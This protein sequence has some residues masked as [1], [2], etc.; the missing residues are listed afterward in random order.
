MGHGRAPRRE[1]TRSDRPPREP[2]H[3]RR[4]FPVDAGPGSPAGIDVLRSAEAGRRVIRG[5][6]WR[7]AG[8]VAGILAGI[9]T[10]ALVL[11]H[12]GVA[13][14]GRYVTVMSLVAIASSVVDVGL[15][16]S[17]SRELAL[18]E[19]RARLPLLAN[20]I[21]QRLLV[22][23]LAALAILCFAL[24]AGYPPTMRVGT[25][26]AG[27]GMFV[28]ALAD[29]LLLPLSV[30]LR[31][32]GLAFVDFLKQLVSLGGVALLVALGAGLTPFF[33]VLILVGLAVLAAV[34]LL[35]GPGAFVRP[36]FDRLD[37]RALLGKALPLAAA[38]VLGQVYFRLVILLM[39]LVSSPRQTGYYGGSL[40]AIEALVGIP[41]LIAGV[42]LPLL[43]AAAR[44]D[45]D[46]LR[47]A[48][49]GLSEGAV[50]AGVLVALVA[51]RAAEPVMRV[52]GGPAF[53]PA[54]AVLRIQ[55]CALLFGALVQIWAVALVA[56]GRQRELILANALGLLGIGAFAAALVVPFGARGG[57]LASVLAD[58]SL[59]CV[60]HWRL[61]AGGVRVAIRAGFLG[62]VALAAA[63]AGAVLILPS[64]P[65]LLA[66][67]LA[68][69]LFLGVGQL[70]GMVP[71]AIHDAF[72]SRALFDRLVARPSGR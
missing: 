17:A 11:R 7:V 31:N 28:V 71:P 41:I 51:A 16:V 39:S 22:T 53:V 35:A 40:R 72:G 19:P 23:P 69:A 45:R 6:A 58:A 61:R 20:V 59:A 38:L 24:A 14:S 63:A 65:D 8:S 44:D 30:Q 33:A 50:I 12:L 55:V 66:A 42:A 70:I 10:A 49:E 47:H 15:N 57:A 54:G 46:R 4:P 36:R 68:G 56:L 21:G 43:A 48:I 2:R 18:R 5:S 64:V 3:E 67:A 60:I 29:A 37:Q 27:V 1:H 26:L 34:P 62:R 9:A 13:Q 52:I 32:A 25:L